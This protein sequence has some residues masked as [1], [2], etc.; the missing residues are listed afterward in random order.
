MTAPVVLLLTATVT[1]GGTI[2]T[3]RVD[4][5]VRLNDYRLALAWWIEHGPCKHIV[6][7]ESSLAPAE[8]FAEQV[9]L[10]NRLGVTFEYLT[11]Q[12]D[13]SPHLGKGYGE[14]GIMELAL[15]RSQTLAG[16]MNIMKV[17]GR[18][19][20]RN[21]AIL[22]DQVRDES[23]D[24][25]CDLREYLTLADCRCFIATPKFL[26]THLFPRRNLCDDSR[27]CFL[28]HVLARATH[29]A[30]A[31]GGTWRLPV[32]TLN[33]IGFGGTRNVSMKSGFSKRARLLAKRL[34]LRH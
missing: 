30:L 26:T 8:A 20:V 23:P 9:A 14:M 13:F 29:A 19:I 4:P 11:F 5:Q 33:V 17:T 18:Y 24:I 28:E 21:A 32:G 2:N 25:I 22:I 1:P 12:Q 31:D 3:A 7:C 16:A 34:L 15:Q 27:G 6:L 10:A